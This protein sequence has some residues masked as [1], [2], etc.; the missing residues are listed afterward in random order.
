MTKVAIGIPTAGRREQ[1]RLTLSNLTR[2]RRLPDRVLI[3]PAEEHDFDRA[4]G[5]ALPFPLD[6]V[7]SA[8]RGA[9]IQRNAI[10]RESFGNEDLLIFF[11]DDFYAAS[12]YI[13]QA[14]ELMEHATDVVIA[15]HHPD[16]DGASGKGVSHDEALRIIELLEIAPQPPLDLTPTY[17][18]YGCNMVVRLAPTRLHQVWFDENLPLYSWLEDVD[19]SRRLSPYGRIVACNRLRGVHLGVKRGRTSGVRFGYSQIANP[20]YMLRKGSLDLP[21]A[22]SQMS[23]N[24]VMN[25]LLAFWPEP[26]VDRA[27]RFKGN[28]I[29]FR[30]LLSGKLHPLNVTELE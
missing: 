30:H 9:S 28:T 8:S 22:L 6:L 4:D 7:R 10:L 14:V 2:Q 11:D 27:G 25:A 21:Y 16:V 26:W 1:L 12:D 15:T 24:V 23:R 19:F 5:Q 3:C 29:A 13:E 17:A 18:G 20:M